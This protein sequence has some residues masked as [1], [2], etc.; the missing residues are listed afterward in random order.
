M[1]VNEILK[2]GLHL[3]GDKE[4]QIWRAQKKTSL[5]HFCGHF[6]SNPPNV[7]AEI[8]QHL[9][10]TEVEKAQVLAEELTIKHFHMAMHHLKKIL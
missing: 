5:H 2:I 3:V 4:K 8:L 9:Q 6:G 1:V 10:T 7:L